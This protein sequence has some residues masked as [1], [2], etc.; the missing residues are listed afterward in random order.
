MDGGM[1]ID[2]NPID[3]GDAM[4]ASEIVV[5]RAEQYMSDEWKAESR[6]TTKGPL[7]S[8][9]E[10][11]GG[12]QE[13]GEED[14]EGTVDV[15]GGGLVMPESSEMV[16][17]MDV[18]EE[19]SE[20]KDM[21]NL[22]DEIWYYILC[23]GVKRGLRARDVCA[24]GL[25][26]RRLR[27][28]SD[29]DCVWEKLWEAATNSAGKDVLAGDAGSN[30]DQAMVAERHS[31][32]SK[33]HARQTAPQVQKAILGINRR[34]YPNRTP[35]HSSAL[36]IPWHKREKQEVLAMH[37]RRV[38]RLQSQLAVLEYETRSLVRSRRTEKEALVGLL[39]QFSDRD[40]SRGETSSRSLYFGG[41]GESSRKQSVG[42]TSS[43]AGE[44]FAESFNLQSG[45]NIDVY[46]L[47]Q[48]VAECREHIDRIGRILRQKETHLRRIGLELQALAHNPMKA[49]TDGVPVGEQRLELKDRR[50]STRCRR[51]RR[52]RHSR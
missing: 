13:A 42:G 17:M 27:R 20:M 47:K 2:S 31:W 45:V 39:R 21:S 43:T 28:I 1:I 40:K 3:K 9:E 30:D 49:N 23:M 50:G 44:D 5:T 6:W 11:K 25:V 35:G 22:P 19:N 15:N 18:E 4:D 52:Y 41:V 36:I 8:T 14:D 46:S 29:G 33:V 24:L 37:R 38:R 32:K 51:D 10:E 12:M 34:L 26:S 48:E 16:V 7:T